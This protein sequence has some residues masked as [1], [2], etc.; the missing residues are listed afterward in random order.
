MKKIL[1]GD[2][3]F[4]KLLAGVRTLDP[5][6]GALYGPDKRNVLSRIQGV[7]AITNFFS[8]LIDS[9][10]LPDS[11]ED[12]GM[13]LMKDVVREVRNS[14]GAGAGVSAILALALLHEG[15]K[16]VV[17]QVPRSEIL[18]RLRAL[19]AAFDTFVVARAARIGAHLAGKERESYLGV[20]KTSIGDQEISEL[21]ADMFMH[22]GEGGNVE[23]KRGEG[24]KT[25]VEYVDGFSFKT[26]PLSYK[27]LGS[28]KKLEIENPLVAVS[29]DFIDLS[30][31]LIDILIRCNKESRPLILVCEGLSKDALEL[32]LHNIRVGSLKAIAVKPPAYGGDKLVACRD[33]AL[34]SA[35]PVIAPQGRGALVGADALGSA[36]RA[37]ITPLSCTLVYAKSNITPEHIAQ[38]AA[39]EYEEKRPIF[40]KQLK[41]RLGNLKGKAAI[42]TVGGATESVRELNYYHSEFA[43]HAI[44][45]AMTDGF[46]PGGCQVFY[47]F[48]KSDTSPELKNLAKAFSTPFTAL[49]KERLEERPLSEFLSPVETA[50]YDVQTDTVRDMLD[51]G[52]ID[53][54]KVIRKSAAA[55]VSIAVTVLSSGA[56]VREE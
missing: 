33:L 23:M 35:G 52:V 22:V 56:I 13:L 15:N 18:A 50:A 45:G 12:T 31:G 2:E 17:A 48:Y 55:A 36:D 5:V 16:L 30:Q 49:L 27:F 37:I 3:V 24:F 40:K 14:A 43:A 34:A 7:P 51:S 11:F 46:L 4:K 39:L 6:V 9:L 29:T 41:E 20:A 47:D 32:V 26:S 25:K 53:S 38:V 42:V 21:M 44:R 1:I 19:G 8:G 28:A 54:A 10:T